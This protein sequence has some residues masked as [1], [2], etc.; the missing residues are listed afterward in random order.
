LQ[1]KNNSIIFLC[2]RVIIV[3]IV[4]FWV[5][6]LCSLVG[7]YQQ[8]REAYLLVWNYKVSCM[9]AASVV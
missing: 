8:L 3:H 7:G 6:K 1:S 4:S 2:F 5:A 9:L